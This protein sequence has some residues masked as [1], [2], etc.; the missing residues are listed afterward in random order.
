MRMTLVGGVQGNE[1]DVGDGVQ[2]MSRTLVRERR[3]M[4]MMLVREL[5]EKK[6]EKDVGGGSSGK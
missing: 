2:G 5:R 6:H 1:K 3:E 4:R